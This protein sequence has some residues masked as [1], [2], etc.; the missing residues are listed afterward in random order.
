MSGAPTGRAWLCCSWIAVISRID[1]LWAI[2]PATPVRERIIASLRA[3]VLRPDDFAGT[4][5]RDDL[6]CVLPVV[7]GPQLAMLAAE[8]L[9]RTMNAPLWLDEAE[10]YASPSS[11]SRSFRGRNSAMRC[12]RKRAVPVPRPQ[13]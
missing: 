10:I 2:G 1:A 5:G 13:D 11:G 7:E 12:C 4:L 3:E 8:K 9:L 6:A